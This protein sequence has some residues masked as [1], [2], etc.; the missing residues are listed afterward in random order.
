MP[1][2]PFMVLINQFTASLSPLTQCQSAPIFAVNICVSKASDAYGYSRHPRGSLRWL[3]NH[4]VAF[5]KMPFS[6][7]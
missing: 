1:L 5:C 4:C 2:P 7:D 6:F 3:V